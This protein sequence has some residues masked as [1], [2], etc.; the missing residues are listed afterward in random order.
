M[1]A[2]LDWLHRHDE[3]VAAVDSALRLRQ[4][5]D[6]R[7]RVERAAGNTWETRTERLLDL[8]ASELGSGM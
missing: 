7:R 5:G 2:R 8:V 6:R 3:F 4:D 1:D